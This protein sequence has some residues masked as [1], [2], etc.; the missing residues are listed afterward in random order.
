MTKLDETL[1]NAEKA[2]KT[3][4]GPIAIKRELNLF[5]GLVESA[6][7]DGESS[8]Y[9]TFPHA[10]HELIVNRLKDLGYDIK[11]GRAYDEV[12]VNWKV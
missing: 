12:E 10:R 2:R 5:L 11:P 7:L 9:T 4:T 1:F 6:A 8:L 3:M